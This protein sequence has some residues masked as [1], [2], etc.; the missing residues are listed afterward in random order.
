MTTNSD[1]PQPWEVTV[2]ASAERLARRP[3]RPI[4]RIQLA[5][6]LA[7]EGNGDLYSMRKRPDPDMFDGAWG[8]IDSLLQ[9]MGTAESGLAS[10]KYRAEVETQLQ[11]LTE[12]NAT[13]DLL[14]VL[15]LNRKK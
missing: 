15:I 8:T 2:E 12:D 7:Y 1:H 4:S 11:L 9:Q 3:K 5:V 14:R 13:R 10:A 6:F